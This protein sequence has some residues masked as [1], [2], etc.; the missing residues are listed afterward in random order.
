MTVLR[1]TFDPA[2]A[3]AQA[4]REAMLARLA[5]LDDTCAGLP[6]VG[7]PKAMARHRARGTL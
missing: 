2:S 3:E 4:N 7:G 1:S 6:E 5:E